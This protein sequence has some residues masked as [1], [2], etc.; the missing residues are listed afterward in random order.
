ML[1]RTHPARAVIELA[2]LCLRGGD[3]IRH[4]LE[5]RLLGHFQD[6]GDL[7]DK[8]HGREVL[9]RIEAQARIQMRVGGVGGAGGHEQRVAVRL[10]AHEGRGADVPARAGLVV[11]DDRLAQAFGQALRQHPAQRIGCATRRPGHDQLDG[12][13]GIGLRMG[14]GDDAGG[15]HG[16][17]ERAAGASQDGEGHGV[18]RS[19]GPLSPSRVSLRAGRVGLAARHCAAVLMPATLRNPHVAEKG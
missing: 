7:R 4:R 2:G 8:G 1:R 14:G 15:K 3:Q 10:F 5:A 17:H 16:E 6:V 13:V 11:H 19:A 9:G 12:T 18:S